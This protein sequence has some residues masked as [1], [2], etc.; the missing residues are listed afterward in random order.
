MSDI[1]Y[2]IKRVSCCI[3][4]NAINLRSVISLYRRIRDKDWSLALPWDGPNNF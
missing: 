4:H 1:A 2:D 3:P